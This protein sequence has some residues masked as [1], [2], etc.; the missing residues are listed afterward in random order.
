MYIY[1]YVCR[2]AYVVQNPPVKHHKTQ[3]E[4]NSKIGT[5]A[6]AKGSSGAIG[7]QIFLKFLSVKITEVRSWDRFCSTS[8]L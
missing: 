2:H 3:R 7:R 1:I 8:W 5:L 4:T 6:L